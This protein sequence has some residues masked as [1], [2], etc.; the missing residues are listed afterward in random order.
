[1]G[2]VRVGIVDRVWISQLGAED[3]SIGDGGD[4]RVGLRGEAGGAR[5]TGQVLRDH[6]LGEISARFPCR[7]PA[8]APFHTELEG[9][10]VAF[11]VRGDLID[12]PSAARLGLSGKVSGR[13]GVRAGGGERSNRFRHARDAIGRN[14]SDQVPPLPRHRFVLVGA[15][16]G[17]WAVHLVSELAFVRS[18]VADVKIDVFAGGESSSAA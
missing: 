1:M 4:G 2:V 5:P 8:A 9:P 10:V 18:V 13:S 17:E 7:A 6:F 16:D 12:D 11:A 3:G 14:A 15:D